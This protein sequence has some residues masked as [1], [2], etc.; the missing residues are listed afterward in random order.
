VGL[1]LA[2]ES[3]IGPPTGDGPWPDSIAI[4][5]EVSAQ[6]RPAR[7]DPLGTACQGPTL[8]SYRRSGD[9]FTPR[10]SGFRLD[11]TRPR[12]GAVDPEVRQ[13]Q[14]HQG[15]RFEAPSPAAHVPAGQE[16]QRFGT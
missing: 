13:R 9:T 10:S 2:R 15:D 7:T 4:S 16:V 8:R 5:T 3:W 11:D 14:G 1:G 12:Y 6:D